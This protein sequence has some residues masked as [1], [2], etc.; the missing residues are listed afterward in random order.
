MIFITG[1]GGDGKLSWRFFDISGAATSPFDSFLVSSQDA[2]SRTSLTQSP[3]PSPVASAGLLIANVELGLGPGLAVTS[4]SGA[5]WD[6][7]NYTGE[8]DSDC[9]ENADICAHYYF[10][11]SGAETWTFTITSH[12]GIN[13]AAG[14]IAFTA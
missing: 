4:P 5:V 9:L 3:S 7:A 11:A 12:P 8:N 14:Y 6:L 13:T 2:S 10:S 1:G